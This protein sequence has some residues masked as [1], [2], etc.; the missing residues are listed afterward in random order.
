MTIFTV[1]CEQGCKTQYLTASYRAEAAKLA[2]YIA[3]GHTAHI[4]EVEAA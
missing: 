2:H 4:D 1:E 3:T